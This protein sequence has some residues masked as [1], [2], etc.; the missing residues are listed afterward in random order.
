M[1]Q[2]TTIAAPDAALGDAVR[3]AI[4]VKPKP[5]GRPGR[6]EAPGVQRAPRRGPARRR[7]RGSAVGWVQSWPDR[8][9]SSASAWAIRG[10]G[11][12]SA[13]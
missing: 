11:R 7:G 8:C 5:P 2:D 4:D 12:R 6:I 10:S 1:L 9:P 3:P 13:A